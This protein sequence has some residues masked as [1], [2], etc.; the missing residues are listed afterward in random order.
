MDASLDLLCIRLKSSLLPLELRR[1]I[2]SSV[3][4]RETT[5]HQHKYGPEENLEDIQ[6]KTLFKVPRCSLH[7]NNTYI[8]MLW[9]GCVSGLPEG[10]VLGLW[11]P[12][13]TARLKTK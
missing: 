12:S 13:G 4:K 10:T 8:A 7:R 6:I 1:A 3:W 11:E 2:R 9:N 5:T